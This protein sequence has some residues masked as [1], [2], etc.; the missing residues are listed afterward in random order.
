MS[1]SDGTG[2][3]P[4]FTRC[5]E[6][7][8]RRLSRW[9]FGTATSTSSTPSKEDCESLPPTRVCRRPRSTTAEATSMPNGWRSTSSGGPRTTEALW[10]NVLSEEEY[11]SPERIWRGPTAATPLWTPH[12][13][14]S[15]SDGA[16]PPND[17]RW[18]SCDNV[19]ACPRCPSVR[20]CPFCY[21]TVHKCVTHDCPFV[22][23]W[24]RQFIL[25]E[26]DDVDDD[27][28]DDWSQDS[29]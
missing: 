29:Q 10:T 9:V 16:R 13:P 23:N 27:D 7:I 8:R 1:G 26:L 28:D 6:T 15:L 17:E 18:R 4:I 20:N 21:A 5:K 11:T 22:D 25:S 19:S 24:V 12:Q 2:C 14:L 3:C